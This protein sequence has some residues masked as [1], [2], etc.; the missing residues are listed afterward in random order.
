MLIF[1]VGEEEDRS[2]G[3]WHLSRHSLVDR[4]MVKC[5]KYGRMEGGDADSGTRNA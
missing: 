2:G 5:M 3:S 1:R 4:P